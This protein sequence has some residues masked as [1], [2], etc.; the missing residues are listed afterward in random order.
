VLNHPEP[1]TP[2]LSLTT[3]PATGASAANFGLITGKSNLHRQLQAQLRFS[4]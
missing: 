2:S 3:N 1:N 4:F